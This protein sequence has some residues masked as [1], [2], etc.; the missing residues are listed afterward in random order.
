[1]SM[2]ETK[3]Y[4]DAFYAELNDGSYLSAKKI[5]PVI[6]ELF[7]P[8][9]VVDIGCGVG[10]WVKVWKD[11][12]QVNDVLG[13]E[14]TYMTQDL[15]ELDKQYLMTAD[16]KMPLT[17]PKKYDLVMSMEVAEHIPEDHADI[18][19]KNLV[20][21]GDIILFS[22]AIKG[23]LGTYHINEQMPEYWA[24]KF[25]KHNYKV[26]D[27]IRPAIWNDT[28]IAYWYRQNTL[29]FIKEERVNEFPQLKKAAEITDAAYLTRIHPEKY[30]AYVEENNQLRSIGGF[31]KYKLYLLKKR[32][33]GDKTP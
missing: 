15:Y 6:N 9:S 14:G 32:L 26:V 28:S 33:K 29:L 25:K 4:D 17:L 22:A 16:L 21:A 30:F 10:Y 3:Y 12:L 5:L 31:I 24:E 1:M 13:I 20:D 7:K 23:Q 8:A 11:D 18:F 19:I 2:Q 27:F